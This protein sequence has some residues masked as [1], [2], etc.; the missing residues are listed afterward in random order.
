M[1]PLQLLLLFLILHSTVQASVMLTPP[2]I[3]AVQSGHM[4]LIGQLI[5]GGAQVNAIN[6]LGR[7]ATHYAVSNNNLPALK[8]L[9]SNGV[10]T[11]LA[12]NDGNTPLDMWHVHENKEML[13]LLHTAGAKPLDLW[14]AAANNDRAAAERLL[15]AG[16]DAKA[17]NDAGKV[18]FD[19]AIEAEH[20]ALAAILLK[21]AVGING[22][23][24]KGWSPLNWAIFGDAWDLVRE[25]IR[26]GADI[27]VG[28][29]Q[30]AFDVA[31]LMESEAKLIEV[32]IAEKGVDAT[33]GQYD[34]TM[35]M[36]TAVKGN[37][38]NAKLLIN[39]KAD[40]NAKNKYDMTALDFAAQ[41]RNIEIFR[42]L[43]EHGAD[44]K[45]W[46]P[47]HQAIINNDWDLVR[48]LIR[49]GADISVGRSQNAFDVATLME[50][51][52]KLIE[53]FIAEKGVDATVGERGYDNTLLIWA[54]HWGRTELVQ[55]LIDNNA[56]LNVTDNY[57]ATALIRAASSGHTEIVKLLIDNDA[58]LN[59]TDNH[60][61]TALIRAAS[62]G[63]TEIVKLLIDNDA[64]LNVTDNHGATALM[65]AAG[66]GHT[67]IFRLLIKHGA[68]KKSYS[69]L[70]QAIMNDDWYL[71]RELIREGADISVGNLQNA[72]DV[73]TLMESETKL[74][75]VFI[76]EKGVDMTVGQDGDTMLM[77]AVKRGNTE[78]AELLIKHG[79]NL[80]IQS[81][82]GDTALIWAANKEYTETVKLLIEHGA[83]PNIQ[84]S[85]GNTAL[86][87][88]ASYWGYTHIVERLIKHGADLNIKNID[89]NTALDVARM[90]GIAPTISLL[91]GNTE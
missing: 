29:S 39:S 58:N 87:I 6:A 2:L 37:I 11:N 55:L 10:D 77:L 28:R 19:I 70:H 25:L 54:E 48:E 88:I 41:N 9:L 78:I 17:E 75:E 47:L 60:G 34:R 79:A 7:T 62:S 89:G 12:D 81:N 23:D 84:N 40:L 1:Q 14:Q 16:A 66:I 67:E 42:L 74:I 82:D 45:T 13:V 52:A 59:V 69:P 68:D 49:E 72:L 65:L 51:E 53:V 5:N 86:I 26:E 61:A 35:L 32:F 73:A 43:I 64:N 63:H 30:N 36:L 46:P 24:K 4:R 80:N 18:P 38:E 85:D 33:V 22:R 83:D 8:L 76:A 91:W 20:Y 3:Q 44:K 50:S 56:N 27:S 57:G 21:A 71:V 31:T 15:T 90:K